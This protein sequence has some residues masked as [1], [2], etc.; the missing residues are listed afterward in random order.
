MSNYDPPDLLTCAEVA[1]ALRVSART[2]V[3]LCREGNLRAYRVGKSWRIEREA[4][5]EYLAGR[6]NREPA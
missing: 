5:D 2:V 6:S 1:D 3:N 4:V